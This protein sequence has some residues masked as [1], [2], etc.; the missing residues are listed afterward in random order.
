ML[1]EGNPHAE[2]GEEKDEPLIIKGLQMPPLG[3]RTWSDSFLF[4]K[5]L[6]SDSGMAFLL[7]AAKSILIHIMLVDIFCALKYMHILMW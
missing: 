1:A 2:D 4:F 3:L 6:C 7:L 5:K